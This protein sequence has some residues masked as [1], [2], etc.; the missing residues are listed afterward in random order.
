MITGINSEYFCNIGTEPHTFAYAPT[1]APFIIVEL[2]ASNL[3]YM[4]YK[5][6]SVYCHGLYWKSLLDSI[7]ESGFYSYL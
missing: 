2:T 4:I 6:C 3:R 7:L 5:A 1:I